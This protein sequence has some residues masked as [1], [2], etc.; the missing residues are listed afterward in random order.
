MTAT[1][2]ALKKSL[3]VLLGDEDL[4]RR[5]ALDELLKAEG[6]Q[7]D[8]F[9]L[10][11]MDAQTS[12]PRD[13]LGAAGTA[14][15]LAERRTVV[16][17]RLL[18]FDPEKAAGAEFGKLPASALLILVAD[19]E[20]GS[21]DRMQKAKGG[22]DKWKKL[23]SDAQGAVLEFNTDANA[24][25]EAVRHEVIAKGMTISERAA[26]ML[27]DMTGGSQSRA[28]EELEKVYL[29]VGEGGGI[30]ERELRAVVVPS[31]DWNVFKMTDAII[32]GQVPEALRQLKIL[33]GSTNKPEGATFQNLIP[34][35]SRSLRLVWQGCV[36]VEAGCTPSRVT[37]EV[38]RVF[39]ERPNLAREQPYRQ[40]QVMSSA[41]RTSMRAVSNAL[42]VLSDTDTRLKGG[43]PS[44]SAVDT[45]ER[46]VLE[47][48]E[49]MG[50]S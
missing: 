33:M 42:Q 27:V 26:D 24:A 28:F 25:K 7:P 35:L 3:I 29:Y 12:Q 19:E 36:C 40:S 15:F 43:L 31:R 47:M 10:E 4:L 23:V 1:E 16:V 44:F 17:R 14:P 32:A 46:M 34:Q 8:D 11:L 45:L 2:R 41:R 49:A 6:V 48:A 5:R 18:A 38:L 21:D 39:P 20:G 50:K 37:P 30:G 22:R 13:W 9:D